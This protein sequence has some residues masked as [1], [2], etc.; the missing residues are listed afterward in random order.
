MQI[1][2]LLLDFL[3]AL[4]AQLTQGVLASV[5]T[6][7]LDCHFQEYSY[8]EKGCLQSEILWGKD[9][10]AFVSQWLQQAAR[11]SF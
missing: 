8:L 1:F 5:V 9:V 3:D 7:K 6:W 4:H 11:L 10:V 2:R